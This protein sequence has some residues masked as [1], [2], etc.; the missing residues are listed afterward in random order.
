MY[1][2]KRK[3]NLESWNEGTEKVCEKS[4]LMTDLET[5]PNRGNT[6]YIILWPVLVLQPNRGYSKCTGDHS[7][8][9]YTSRSTAVWCSHRPV[10]S[11][12]APP[13]NGTFVKVSNSM[14]RRKGTAVTESAPQWDTVDAEIKGPSVGSWELTKVLSLKPGVFPAASQRVSFLGN[15]LIFTVQA[16]L[17]NSL[18]LDTGHWLGVYVL[19]TM[20]S[21]HTLKK[22]PQAMKRNGSY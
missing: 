15:P 6:N 2:V 4:C 7:W 9:F 18:L 14:K 22:G 17:Y 3:S 16:K 11:A 20:T 21:P 10:P 8:S 19:S 1:H 5:K 12:W 13:H